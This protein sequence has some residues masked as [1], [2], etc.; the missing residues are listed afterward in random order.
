MA[1]AKGKIHRARHC[2]GLD[3]VSIIGQPG[4]QWGADI[5]GPLPETCIG[6]RYVLVVT[7]LFTKWVEL[8][9]LKDVTAKTVA[10]KLA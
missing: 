10:R 9:A 5:L 1:Y 7:D 8:F 3:T 2:E 4:A 6:K